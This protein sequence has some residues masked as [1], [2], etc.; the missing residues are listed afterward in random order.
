MYLLPGRNNGR[1]QAIYTEGMHIR[2]EVGKATG[3]VFGN[4]VKYEND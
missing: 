2:W 1:L 3:E 4:S